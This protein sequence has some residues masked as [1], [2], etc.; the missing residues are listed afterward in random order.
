MLA[1]REF[2]IRFEFS[3]LEGILLSFS[4]NDAMIDVQR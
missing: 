2:S 1:F 4:F 3:C